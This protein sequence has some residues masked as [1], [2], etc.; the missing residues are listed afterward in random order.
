MKKIILILGL[1]LS[2]NVN[3]ETSGNCGA[4]NENT[5][6][7]DDCN[8]SLDDE[9]NLKIWG[10]G[11][12]ADYTH[13]YYDNPSPWGTDI[14]TVEISGITSIGTLAFHQAQL[15]SAKI[16]NSVLSIGD[17]AFQSMRNL[18]SVNF[19]E[20]SQLER[21]NVAVFYGDPLLTHIE[22]PDSLKYLG[23]Y[24]FGASGVTSLILP[25][26]LFDEGGLGM[27]HSALTH[28]NEI[29][30][31]EKYQKKC[32]DYLKDADSFTGV[33]GG[34]VPLED[35]DLKMYRRLGNEY[36]YGGKFYDSLGKIGTQ[37][38]IKKRIYTIDDANQVAGKVNSVKIRYR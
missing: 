23:H 21:I 24:N 2:F 14:S 28:I 3:A 11:K 6:T 31:S 20:N 1:V 12:M 10:T 37:N 27:A 25:D 16:G 8:W 15:T 33:D 22:L 13:T 26:S 38:Y 35:V 36:L 30:C 29:Y 32:A 18:T 34:Y 17:G 9:G 5:Q 19:E 4:Y 7:Y